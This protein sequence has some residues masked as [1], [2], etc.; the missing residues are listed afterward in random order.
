MST[1]QRTRV[2]PAAFVAVALAASTAGAGQV[3]LHAE[4][5]TGAKITTIIST[6]T[7]TTVQTTLHTITHTIF[8]THASTLISTTISTNTPTVQTIIQTIVSTSIDSLIDS[9]ID[10]LISTIISTSVS[11]VTEISDGLSRAAQDCLNAIN[12]NFAKVA[13]AQRKAIGKCIKDRS[14][15]RLAGESIEACFDADRSGK[16]A[17]ARA[18][19]KRIARARCDEIPDFGPM[20]PNAINW[21]A[22]SSE[23]SLIYEFLGPDLDSAI[24]PA[25]DR[26]GSKCQQ[27]VIKAAGKCHQAKLDEF[28]KCKKAGMQGRVDFPGAHLPFADPNDI[29]HCMGYDPSGKVARECDPQFG[30]L[31]RALAKHCSTG[32]LSDAFPGRGASEPSELASRLD[33]ILECHVCRALNQA[34]GL[35]Q[36]CDDLDDGELNASCP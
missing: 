4:P 22:V 28:N 15:N 21:A 34:D 23:L 17:K 33:E 3:L 13:R 9:F 19:T 6:T 8:Q 14:K 32:S 18:K 12:K 16:V 35:T 26:R 24:I 11:T 1:C 2:G 27:S 5:E 31:G 7:S 20:D 30:R 10:S 25:S 29:G 36:N